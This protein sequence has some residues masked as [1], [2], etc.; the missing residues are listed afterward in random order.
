MAMKPEDQELLISI[1]NRLKQRLNRNLINNEQNAQPKQRRKK[2]PSCLEDLY[3]LNEL[4]FTLEQELSHVT[5][6]NNSIYG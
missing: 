3:L 1:R 6:Q 2:Q 4:F 5:K